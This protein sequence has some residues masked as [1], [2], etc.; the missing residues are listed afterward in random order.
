VPWFPDVPGAPGPSVR[1]P[2]PSAVP[3]VGSPGD[4][5][6]RA[7]PVPPPTGIGPATGPAGFDRR[8]DRSG[9]ARQTAPGDG[10]AGPVDGR[11]APG[12]G[13]TDRPEFLP[14]LATGPVPR[15][16]LPPGS[17]PILPP[18]SRPI[19][20]PGSPP[21]LAAGSGEVLDPRLAARRFEHLLAAAA[22]ARGER[23][24]L[25][26]AGREE[27]LTRAERYREAAGDVRDRVQDAWRQVAEALAPFGVTELRQVR[28][29]APE[30]AA[31]PP[32]DALPG[33]GLPDETGAAPARPAL[34]RDG[35]RGQAS[36]PR[37][38]RGSADQAVPTSL[39]ADQ[40]T[41]AEPNVTAELER[42]RM[43]CLRALASGAELRGALRASSSLSV[44]L[45]TAGGCALVAVVVAVARVFFG[46]V[47]LPCVLGGLIVGAAVVSI[48]TEGG[49]A[50]AAGRSALLAA[51]TAGAVVLATLRVAPVEPLGIVVSLLALAAA[52]RFGL[53]FG[54]PAKPEKPAARGAAG[55]R[56]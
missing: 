55:K 5:G 42:A 26:Q 4:G 31:G 29:Q 49:G 13:G 52:V 48:G 3:P 30:L 36:G 1:A 50:R 11:G 22:A 25:A 35:R 38:R 27:A 6:N 47:G 41:A 7:R 16:I 18:G 45:A 8:A 23:D 33:I 28:D 51:G 9:P 19:L 39:A 14:A 12:P 43:L 37:R 21:G 53:G 44:G 46:A 24:A 40:D 32:A 10:L 54:A 2:R 56:R 34:G 15:P 17:R 20:P